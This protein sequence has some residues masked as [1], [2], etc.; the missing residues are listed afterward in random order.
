MTNQTNATTDQAAIEDWIM[1]IYTPAWMD[2]VPTMRPHADVLR[3]RCGEP[4]APLVTLIYSAARIS[5]Q[6][7]LPTE[8]DTFTRDA[9]IA[10]AYVVAKAATAVAFVPL[11]ALTETTPLV[12]DLLGAAFHAAFEAAIDAAIRQPSDRLLDVPT[13]SYYAD[14]AARHALGATRATLTESARELA[15]RINAN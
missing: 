9:A 10:A 3:N 6:M 13:A 11:A 14:I 8:A 12:H 15:Q 5:V 2:L 1:R 4:A 7:I